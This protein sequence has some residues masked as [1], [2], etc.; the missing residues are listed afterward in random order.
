MTLPEDGNSCAV[1]HPLFGE[2]K[3]VGI[4]R[5]YDTLGQVVQVAFNNG[6]VGSFGAAS[7]TS[8]QEAE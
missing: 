1:K 7:L 6:V 3:T 8:V 2:G 4:P 5:T